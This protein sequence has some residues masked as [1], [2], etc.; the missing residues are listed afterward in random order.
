MDR[1]NR[2]DETPPGHSQ[3]PPIQMPETSADIDMLGPGMSFPGG[4]EAMMHFVNQQIGDAEAQ[5]HQ[6]TSAPK[7]PTADRLDQLV[8]H[9]QVNNIAPRVS[10]F[11]INSMKLGDSPTVYGNTQTGYR[12]DLRYGA[13]VRPVM[14]CHQCKT[15][16][17]A[18]ELVFCGHI[19]ID[20]KG[21]STTCTKRYCRTC[22]WNWYMEQAPK[23]SP[24]TEPMWNIWRCPSCRKL[25]CCH[26]CRTFE[27]MQRGLDM[28]DLQE[29]AGALSPARCLARCLSD[30]PDQMRFEGDNPE[31]EIHPD[32]QNEEN[33]KPLIEEPTTP[34]GAVRIKEE[35]PKK[36]KRRKSTTKGKPKPKPGKAVKKSP[37]YR[38]SNRRN[39]SS[40]AQPSNVKAPTR[41]SARIKNR[42]VVVS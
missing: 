10:N 9:R 32:H 3:L 21:Y 5:L 29:Q 11:N 20:A 38:P 8:D 2:K 22:L 42:A 16:K 13:D 30:A 41:V 15:N 1:M 26:R 34:T 23:N 7:S 17:K 25:C 35:E 19:S 14:N 6:M 28:C 24:D 31:V 33:V 12:A 18:D 36:K 37:D 39:S 27:K 4:L 40:E